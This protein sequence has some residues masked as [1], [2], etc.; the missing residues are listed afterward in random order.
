MAPRAPDQRGSH[1]LRVRLSLARQVQ[2]SAEVGERL[3]PPSAGESHIA[4]K[5]AARALQNMRRLLAL[6]DESI[7]R[8]ERFVP[9][10]QDPVGRDEIPTEKSDERRVSE[11]FRFTD[12]FVLNLLDAAHVDHVDD[13]REVV[14]RACDH[15]RVRG[16]T[17]LDRAL[18]IVATGRVPQERLCG[19]DRRQRM[20]AQVD[21]LESLC[22]RQRLL[23]MLHSALA[24]AGEHLLASSHPSTRATLGEGSA[25]PIRASAARRC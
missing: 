10:T 16:A 9:F 22:Q 21:E 19:S 7:R 15:H 12:G 3:I 1:A 17:D 11:P 24:L 8:G 6:R 13:D 4:P 25:R 2:T 20:H 23:G 18:E 14:E 5:D